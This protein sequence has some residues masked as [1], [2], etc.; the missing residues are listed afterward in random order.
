MIKELEDNKRVY[1]KDLAKKFDVSEMTVR[2]D[3]NRLS[4]LGLVTLIHGGAVFNEGGATALNV[5]FRER[6]MQRE[7]NILGQYCSTLIGEGNSVYLH[8]GSTL[9]NI[10][11]ALI[12]RQNIA[13]LS[14][15]L[16][17]L[18]M[19]SAAKNIQLI[20]LPGIYESV[21]KGFFGDMTQRA[22]K[23]FRI[24]IAFLGADAIS[25]EHGLMLSLPS[26]AGLVRAVLESARKKIVVMDHTKINR[27]SFVKICDLRDLNQI[28]TDKEAD[29][30][31]VK[32]VRRL[33]VEV[34]QV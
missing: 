30:D 11:D 25:L 26:D 2:R 3:L 31:F 22:V 21:H 15:S 16:Q 10:A 24:D 14:N 29:E 28:I 13:V 20:A 9:T 27:E 1:T 12:T 32:K 5:T 4:A 17:I 6:Q 34:S 8:C 23:N 33:G 7:K 19:L 18:N